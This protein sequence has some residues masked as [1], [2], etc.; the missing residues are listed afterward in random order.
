MISQGMSMVLFFPFD[1]DNP[2]SNL[3][4]LY[5]YQIPTRPGLSIHANTMQMRPIFQSLSLGFLAY[6]RNHNSSGAFLS[7]KPVIDTELTVSQEFASLGHQVSLACF[8]VAISA[9]E[10]KYQWTKDGEP[11][12]QSFNCKI[13]HNFLVLTPKR[14]EDFGVYMCS[15]FNSVGMSNHSIEVLEVDEQET[16]VRES[17]GKNNDSVFAIFVTE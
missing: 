5:A 16:V 7:G 2:P 12:L 13:F 9:Y 14:K 8:V 1:R 3:Q 10:V 6:N 11:L 17:K 4:Q 15:A